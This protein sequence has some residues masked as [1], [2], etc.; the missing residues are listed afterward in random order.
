MRGWA[1]VESGLRILSSDQRSLFWECPRRV[2]TVMWCA[3]RFAGGGATG[4]D[5]SSSRALRR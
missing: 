4:R 3:M 2:L 5:E 1:W